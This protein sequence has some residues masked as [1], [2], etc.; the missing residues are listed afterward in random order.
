MRKI[1]RE[2]TATSA[3]NLEKEKA[4]NPVSIT[5]RKKTILEKA[6]RY[7]KS[8]ERLVKEKQEATSN[9]KKS[10]IQQR[11]EAHRGLQKLYIMEYRS[12]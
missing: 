6:R 2:P 1:M 11:I 7:E 10:S 12:L 5:Q 4:E 3:K 9:K 8:I